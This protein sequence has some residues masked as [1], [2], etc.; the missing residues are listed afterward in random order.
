VLR[1]RN[2]ISRDILVKLY[3]AYILPHFD[4]YSTVWHFCSA[5]NRDK[6]EALNKRILRFILSDFESPYNVLLPN[7]SVN[8]SVNSLLFCTKVHF[9]LAIWPIWETRSRSVLLHTT[10]METIY[11]K[12][13]NLKI[14]LLVTF[15]YLATKQWNSLPN[16][17]QVMY[18]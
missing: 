16:F 3:K 13:P 10:C 5:N 9:S 11:W 8:A 1:F 4:Y 7:F 12:C 15:T 2:L 18:M 17:T 14:Q 6:I